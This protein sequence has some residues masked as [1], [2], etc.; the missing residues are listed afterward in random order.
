SKVMVTGAAGF[1]AFHLIESLLRSGCEVVGIDNFD[2]FYERSVKER[3]LSDLRAIA[4]ESGAGFE[5]HEADIRSISQSLF[6]GITSVIHLA[7]KAGVRPSLLAPE[8]YVS[9]NLQGT[10]RMLE[11]SRE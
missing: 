9:V 1:I 10:I 2:A 11:L 5:F 7:A 6:E 4:K 3:N 8:E